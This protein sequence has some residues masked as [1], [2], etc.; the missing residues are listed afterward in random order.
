MYWKVKHEIPP[1]KGEG[2]VRLNVGKLAQV[3][4]YKPGAV[5]S[6]SRH[7]QDCF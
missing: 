6:R 5:K 3:Y 2:Q 4:I 1:D 7:A